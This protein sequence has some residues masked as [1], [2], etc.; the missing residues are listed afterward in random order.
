MSQVEEGLDWTEEGIRGGRVA[1]LFSFVP[2]L[3]VREHEGGMRDSLGVHIIQR[4]VTADVDTA[5][6]SEGDIAQ[7]VGR[8]PFLARCRKVL[9]GS[10]EP[11]EGN[12]DEVHDSGVGPAVDVMVGVEAG[13]ECSEDGDI[14]RVDAVGRFI[15]V[16]HGFEE[17]EVELMQA[18][19]EGVDSR[20]WLTQVGDPR[21][22][23]Q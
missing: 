16:A 11:E 1:D 22:H 8:G 9:R 3:L 23:R 15:L 7:A 21:A 12:N 14:D 4:R 20:I 17:L 19:G 6:D 10:Q 13:R 18:A 5:V 2:V